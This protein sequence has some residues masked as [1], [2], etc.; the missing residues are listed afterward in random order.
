MD[1][2]KKGQPVRLD[3]RVGKLELKNG[4]IIWKTIMD[5]AAGKDGMIKSYASD[6]LD[7]TSGKTAATNSRYSKIGA[8]GSVKRGPANS[9][10][11][12]NLFSVATPS[13]KPSR[14]LSRHRESP[15][16]KTWESQGY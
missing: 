3:F 9:D 11:R 6:G 2:A 8:G 13:I 1:A 15:E 10:V 14:A 5:S 16:L 12:N 7:W 4:E